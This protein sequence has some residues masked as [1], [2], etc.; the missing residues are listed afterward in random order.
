MA[1][2]LSSFPLLYVK[3]SKHKLARNACSLQHP[4][5]SHTDPA[6]F[7]VAPASHQ[8][9]QWPGRRVGSSSV[10]FATICGGCGNGA[11]AH[12]KGHVPIT[13]S[14][15]SEQPLLILVLELEACLLCRLHHLRDYRP[16]RGRNASS[17]S[18]TNRWLK[19]VFAHCLIAPRRQGRC[20][21]KTLLTTRSVLV[22]S[23]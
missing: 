16:A 8:E 10:L 21:K 7:R 3:L 9:A 13:Y 22:T 20:S 4:H 15:A 5:H 1:A 23:M 18:S 11:A 6:L 17:G 14:L 2:D 19:T 12:P